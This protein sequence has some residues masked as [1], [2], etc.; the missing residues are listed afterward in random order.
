MVALVDEPP[1]GEGLDTWLQTERARC[2]ADSLRRSIA[3]RT[4]ALFEPSATEWVEAA[5]DR[6]NALA[7]TRRSLPE[8]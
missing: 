6:C 1:D 5:V 3:W 7:L 4:E 2:S 8:L